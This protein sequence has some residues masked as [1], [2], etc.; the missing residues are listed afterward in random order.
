MSEKSVPEWSQ[1]QKG[2][3]CEGMKRNPVKRFAPA[4][5]PLKAL[6]INAWLKGIGL[7]TV[8]IRQNQSHLMP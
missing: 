7:E 6:S 1:W 8:E 2:W 3:N 4:E 5:S